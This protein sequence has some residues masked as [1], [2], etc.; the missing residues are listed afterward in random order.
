M[1]W[2]WARGLAGVTRE[3]VGEGDRTTGRSC[4]GEERAR[5]PARPPGNDQAGEKPEN[6]FVLGDSSRKGPDDSPRGAGPGRSQLVSPGS[7]GGLAARPGF[8][9]R[10]VNS[11]ES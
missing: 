3:G 5:I 8:L 10:I 4:L 1:E 2:G 9:A 6:R 11:R 7:V